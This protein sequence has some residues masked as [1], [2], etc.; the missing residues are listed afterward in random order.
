[1][2]TENS[3]P[4]NP[5]TSLAIDSAGDGNKPPNGTSLVATAPSNAPNPLNVPQSVGNIQIII[6]LICGYILVV[7]SIIGVCILLL[8][9]L[10][11][12]DLIQFTSPSPFT[13]D[14]VRLSVRGLITLA[15]VFFCH[16]LIQVGER[17][18]IPVTLLRNSEDL[19][20]LLGGNK[21]APLPLEHLKEF[22]KIIK[23][24]K[25]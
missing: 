23:S 20:L 22:I 16:R 17:M 19:K 12:I 6:R 9:S 18:V 11:S 3:E 21:I 1:M 15:G 2:N 14:Y 7:L 25:E 5:Q 10:R 4:T 24:V 8:S 13:Y